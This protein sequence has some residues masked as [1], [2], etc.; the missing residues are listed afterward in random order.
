MNELS[1][2]PM[3][4]KFMFTRFVSPIAIFVVLQN[5]SLMP[6]EKKKKSKPNKLMTLI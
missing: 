1:W 4:A 3:F 5:P 6:F 2:L